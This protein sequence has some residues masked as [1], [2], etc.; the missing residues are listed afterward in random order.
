MDLFVGLDVALEETSLCI[1][2]KEV[3]LSET[4]SD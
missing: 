3:S 1:I 2:D 4:Q